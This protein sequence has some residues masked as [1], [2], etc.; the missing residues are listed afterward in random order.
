MKTKELHDKYT[1]ICNEYIT[2]FLKKHNFHSDYS[3]NDIWVANE[4]GT[5][6]LIEDMFVNFDDVRYDID[7][8]IP[9]E[10]FYKWYSQQERLTLIGLK[11]LNYKSF[12]Q[13][14]PEPYTEKD[15]E[16]IIELQRK[17]VD[18]KQSL[19]N[20]MAEINKNPLFNQF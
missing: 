4:P 9:E 17:V 19:N 6:A 20:A 7:N 11:Y 18:A 2:I 3:G 8:D 13:G 14:A 5:I 1:D 15:I 12:C 10:K 16:E